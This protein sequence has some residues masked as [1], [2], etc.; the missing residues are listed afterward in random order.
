MTMIISCMFLLIK[1][2]LARLVHFHAAGTHAKQPI[3][4]IYVSYHDHTCV[5]SYKFEDIN[6]YIIIHRYHSIIV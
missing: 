6:H 5:C 4:L 2:G 1:Y 3:L